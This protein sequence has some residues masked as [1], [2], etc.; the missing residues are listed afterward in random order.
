M[1]VHLRRLHLPLQ[2]PS[3]FYK[4]MVGIITEIKEVD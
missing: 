4:R 2:L 3:Q 1:P